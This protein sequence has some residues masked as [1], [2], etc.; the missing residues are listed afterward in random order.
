MTI[1]VLLV[2]LMLSLLLIFT[3]ITTVTATATAI[4]GR[5]KEHDD[6]DSNNRP[7]LI[8]PI[9]YDNNNIVVAN[10]NDNDSTI[11]NND[12]ANN[13]NNNF[14]LY[15]QQQQQQRIVGGEQSDIDEFPYFGKYYTACTSLLHTAV[16]RF[17]HSVSIAPSISLL[18]YCAS[19]IRSHSIHH[20]SVSVFLLHSRLKTTYVMCHFTKRTHYTTLTI[21]F[22]LFKYVSYVTKILYCI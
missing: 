11:I 18:L 5:E 3:V 10:N 12:A 20:S 7:L 8:R 16:F 17:L 21:L 4:R 9:N 19:L 15:E 22:Y 6:Y 13:N 1:I 2:Q 14:L